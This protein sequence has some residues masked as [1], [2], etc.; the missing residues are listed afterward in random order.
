VLLIQY[1]L[2]KRGIESAP[3]TTDAGID[4]VV[5]SIE[6]G[7]RVDVTAPQKPEDRNGLS[8]ENREM[9]QGIFIAG[10]IT[11]GTAWILWAGL[12]VWVALRRAYEWGIE[13][14]GLLRT[15]NRAL[16]W[17]Q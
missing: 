13:E 16:N 1:W 11:A 6:T 7:N 4:L 5:Y 17:L 2:L 8:P 9:L 15:L 12:M 3:M 14:R 10:I